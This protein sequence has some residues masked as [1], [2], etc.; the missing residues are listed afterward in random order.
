[1]RRIRSSVV[2]TAIVT[3][4]LAACAGPPPVVYPAMPGPIYYAVSYQTRGQVT[5]GQ[6]PRRSDIL[7]KDAKGLLAPGKTVAFLPPDSCVTT[8]VSPS[9]ATQGQSAITMHC[10]ALLASLE[11]EVAIAG[12]SVVSWQAIKSGGS[13]AAQEKAK[14]LGVDVLFEI[15]QLS[16]EKREAGALQVTDLDFTRHEGPG[17]VAPL[18]VLPEVFQKCVGYIGGLGL[19][20]GTEFMSTV[21]LK[22]VDVKTARALWLY[23]NTVVEVVGEGSNAQQTL[24]FGAKGERPDPPT[25]PSLD[26]RKSLGAALIVSGVL[27]MGIGVVMSEG[28]GEGTLGLVTG[29][30]GAAAA[31]IGGI[32]VA[33]NKGVQVDRTVP[34]PKYPGPDATL[35]EGQAQIDP[36]NTA[37]AAV[38]QTPGASSKYSVTASQD[39]NRDLDRERMDRLTKKSTEDFVGA[40]KKV[41][42]T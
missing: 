31:V 40:L 41:A 1:M 28:A 14:Q 19:K 10:G 22:A 32:V 27:F 33:T 34:E 42:G 4:L 16:P 8:S 25:V 9:G 35:C 15:N 38:G 3:C 6:L 39:A 18:A 24:Y 20:G 11:A 26:E 2:A 7:S 29:G 12:Y 13:V 23:Q 36:F 17:K 21:N 30:L 5:S 37:P